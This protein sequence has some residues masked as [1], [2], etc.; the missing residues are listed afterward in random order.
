MSNLVP[1]L[2]SLQEYVPTSFD[3]TQASL[4]V[5]GRRVDFVLWDT[6]GKRVTAVYSGLQRFDSK[7]A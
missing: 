7:V 6:S 3:K 2:L 1:P 4:Q 5:D